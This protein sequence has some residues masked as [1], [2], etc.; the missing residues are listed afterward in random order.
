MI[1]NP[2]NTDISNW[3]DF[4]EYRE[5]VYLKN[6]VELKNHLLIC[7]KKDGHNLVRVI[8]YQNSVYDLTIN[9][10]QAGA[11]GLLVI[12]TQGNITSQYETLGGQTLFT[13]ISTG[14]TGTQT[15]TFTADSSEEI[16]LIA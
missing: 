5:E 13:S 12:G 11:G 16:L 8:G 2:D 10:T 6:I 14:S 7:Y 3:V 15:L 9:I 4:I 1:C